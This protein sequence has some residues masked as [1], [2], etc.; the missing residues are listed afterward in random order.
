METLVDPAVSRAKFDREVGLYQSIER[1]YC[2]RGWFLLR[3][4]FPE[5]YVVFACPKVSPPI[6]ILGALLD[7]TNYDFW[8]PSVRLVNPFTRAPYK[9]AELPTKLERNTGTAHTPAGDVPAI[10]ALMQ[11]GY[12]PDALPFLCIPGVREYHENPAHTGDSWLRRRGTGE[13]TL[14]FILEQIAKYGTDPIS[15]LQVE[16]GITQV[17]L[18]RTP[19]PT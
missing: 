9:Y 19:P 3:A 11:P 12:T 14:F 8:A 7:F 2:T 5:V 13:G 16:F 15:G 18:G 6:V 10:Q 17:K 4:V 1:E